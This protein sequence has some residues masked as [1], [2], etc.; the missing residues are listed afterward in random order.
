LLIKLLIDS[1]L[2]ELTVLA[3]LAAQLQNSHWNTTI[4]QVK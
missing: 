3:T 4:N 1:I 2:F